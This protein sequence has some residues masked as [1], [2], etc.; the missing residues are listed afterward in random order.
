MG[1]TFTMSSGTVACGHPMA[2]RSL[3]CP[4]D[5]WITVGTAANS[6]FESSHAVRMSEERCV[7]CACACVRIRMCTP[8]YALCLDPFLMSI[9]EHLNTFRNSTTAK[10]GGMQ[11]DRYQQDP[12]RAVG[13]CW[14]ISARTLLRARHLWRVPK[15]SPFDSLRL[16]HARCA[17]A[18]SL[19]IS[20]FFVRYNAHRIKKTL[21]VP[22]K[23]GKC[24]SEYGFHT[25]TYTCSRM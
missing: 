18:E 6:S 4:K 19:F 10:V 15:V 3:L 11:H 9:F 23:T 13:S 25:L 24:S 21:C 14:G 22:Y 7:M 12:T 1:T 5:V 2:A 17:A 8:D 20:T 16:F